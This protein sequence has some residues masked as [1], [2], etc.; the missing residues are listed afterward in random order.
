MLIPFTNAIFYGLVISASTLRTEYR[1]RNQDSWFIDTISLEIRHP[2]T[3]ILH[4]TEEIMEAAHKKG[5]QTVCRDHAS[6]LT[7]SPRRVKPNLYFKNPISLFRSQL[8]RNNIQF[9]Y[10]SDNSYAGCGID[11]VIA[12]LDRMS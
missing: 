9:D 8:P 5:H 7:L 4:C 11:W 2:L 12:D 6:M 1:I 3:A 10:Q